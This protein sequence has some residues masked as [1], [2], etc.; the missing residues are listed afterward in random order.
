MNAIEMVKDWFTPPPPVDVSGGIQASGGEQ[1]VPSSATWGQILDY[2]NGTGDLGALGFYSAGT[3]G[4]VNRNTA[5]SYSTL[6]RCVTLLSSICAQLVACGGLRIETLDGNEVKNRKTKL[7]L[8][9]LTESPDGRT[10]AYQWFE[11]A[12]M[13]YLLDG[14]AIIAVD[15]GGLGQVVGLRRMVGWDAEVFVGTDSRMKMYR[16]RAA[17]DAYDGILEDITETNIIHSRWPL[18]R[19]VNSSSRG[20]FALAPVVAMRP[21]LEIG[22]RGDEYI[23]SFFSKNSGGLKSKLAISVDKPLREEQR[24]TLTEYLQKYMNS[25]MPLVMA[26]NPKFTM[27][28]STPQDAESERL[29]IFQ[30][31]EIARVFGV[32]APLIG[33]DVTQW[34]AGIEQLSKLFWRYG[35]R[36]HFDRFMSAFS[37]RLLERGQVFRPNDM[38]LLRGDSAGIS[39]LL[40]ALQGDAQRPP[41]ITIEEGRRLAGFPADG[42]PTPKVAEPVEPAPEP[43]GE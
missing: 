19:R 32:P 11:D 25:H 39:T 5:V 36:Q 2:A 40:M 27:L 33:E 42:A 6:N 24:D 41:L 37:M 28:K 31:R 34:G 10:P 14:N 13:D 4:N 30:V 38:D 22:L 21:A 35:A 43:D 1:M 8:D 29:R 18:L 20:C 3:V 23:R 12:Y 17:S 9:L 7:V 26:G 16:A 15:R